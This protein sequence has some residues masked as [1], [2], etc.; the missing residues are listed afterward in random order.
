MLGTRRRRGPRGPTLAGAGS[1][2]TH[3][4]ELSSRHDIGGHGEFARFHL[5]GRPG[6][7]GVNTFAKPANV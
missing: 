1:R 5:L 6:P 4:H 2:F 3:I 7:L